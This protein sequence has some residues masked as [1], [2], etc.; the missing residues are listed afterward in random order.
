[1]PDEVPPPRPTNPLRDYWDA[2][3]AYY[4]EVGM[5]DDDAYDDWRERVRK[6]R[7]QR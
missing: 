1:M 2:V 4:R 7:E 5:T 3:D 6:F